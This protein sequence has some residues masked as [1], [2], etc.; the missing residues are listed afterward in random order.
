LTI[1]AVLLFGLPVAISASRVN[2]DAAL[3]AHAQSARGRGHTGRFALAIQLA[4]SMALVVGALLFACTL[5]NLNKT[6]GGFERW[7]V[8]YAQPRFS[9][10]QVPPDRAAAVVRN[11]R[12]YGAASRIARFCLY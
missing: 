5:W 1:I 11:V 6:S 3:R 12:C 9:P 8:L 10:A 2:A 7:A 4:A